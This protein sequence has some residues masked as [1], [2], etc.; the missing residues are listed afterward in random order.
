MDIQSHERYTN[1]TVETDPG[2]FSTLFEPL[3]TDLTELCTYVKR[4]FIHPSQTSQFRPALDPA[5]RDEDPLYDGVQ[6]LLKELLARHPEGLTLDRMPAERLIVS[7][8][9]HA[10]LLASILRYKNIPVRCRAGFARYLSERND[11]YVDHWVCEVWSKELSRWI[12]VDPDQQIVDIPP[13]DF[14]T[15]GDAWLLCR[16][17]EWNANVFGIK[18]SWGLG[19]IRTNLC[20]DLWNVLGT[21]PRYSDLPP[22]CEVEMSRMKTHDLQ[23]LDEL[24]LLLQDVDYEWDNVRALASAQPKLQVPSGRGGF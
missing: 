8:R 10:L 14:L 1:F 21:E 22:I 18:R 5:M 20:L 13:D 19:R 17:G 12:F 23:M 9:F 24:A 15:A 16:S 7:C 2:E 11:K 4:Q 3:P 6:D